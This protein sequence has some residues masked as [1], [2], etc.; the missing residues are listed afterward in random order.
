MIV[1]FLFLFSSIAHADTRTGLVG[2]WQ[3]EEGS[4]TSAYDSSGNGNT[5]TLTNAPS[6][7]AGK[8]GNYA[9]SFD[10]SNYVNLGSVAS[11]NTVGTFSAWIYVSSWSEGVMGYGSTNAGLYVFSFRINS[12]SDGVPVDGNAY[13]ELRAYDQGV[14]GS[15]SYTLH[16]STVLQR[17]T[18]Y[19][20][21]LTAD[22]SV[23]KIYVNGNVET[24][25]AFLG[26]NIGKWV[27]GLTTPAGA[28]KI[29]LA[30]QFV[31]NSPSNFF[32]GIID[33]VRIYNRALSASDVTELYN[34]HA[35]H[36][37]NTH[38]NNLKTN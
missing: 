25:V 22:G 11:N 30:S 4:G 1:F 20:V 7:V 32:N 38:L 6:W 23:N 21:V 28:T 9:L 3:F 16:G 13:M 15:V 8:I 26:S 12:S 34:Q 19:H 5:G 33:D 35:I 24:I 10:G 36:L 2:W 14:G 27:G 18:W 31:S 29:Y 17:N 37:N